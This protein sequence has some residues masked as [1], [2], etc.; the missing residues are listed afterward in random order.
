MLNLVLRLGDLGGWFCFKHIAAFRH[1]INSTFFTEAYCCVSHV[2]CDTFRMVNSNFATR[3][4][5]SLGLYLNL[6]CDYTD[7]KYSVSIVLV[8]CPMHLHLTSQQTLR[9]RKMVK[10]QTG[11]CQQSTIQRHIMGSSNNKSPICP[12]I[13]LFSNMKSRSSKC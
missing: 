2:I 1:T 12:H 4:L 10:V 8:I 7:M 6:E 5:N 9:D 3:L 11:V 13:R